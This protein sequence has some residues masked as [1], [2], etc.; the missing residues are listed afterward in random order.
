MTISLRAQE[1]CE[2]RGGRPGLPVPNSPYGL[3]AHKATLNLNRCLKF[4]LRCLCFQEIG[5][6]EAEAII[7]LPRQ[8]RVQRRRS[9]QRPGGSGGIR[10]AM[11]PRMTITVRKWTRTCATA[12][13]TATSLTIWTGQFTD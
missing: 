9:S 8:C 11:T 10:L 3:C 13:T 5:E 2:S 12:K 4:G 1:L 6:N 7:L